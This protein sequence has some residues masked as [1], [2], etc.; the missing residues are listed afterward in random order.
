LILLDEV[1]SSLG[2]NHRDSTVYCLRDFANSCDATVITVL[3]ECD[4]GL[5][6]QVINANKV[7]K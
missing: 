7:I 5:F 3:H 2:E 1:L 4:K 6:S